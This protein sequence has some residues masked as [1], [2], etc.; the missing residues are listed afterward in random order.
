MGKVSS[1]LSVLLLLLKVIIPFCDLKLKSHPRSQFVLYQV[2][3][4]ELEFGFGFIF[5][6]QVMNPAGKEKLGPH[7]RKVSEKEYAN[8]LR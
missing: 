6:L 3:W 8:L 2:R 4:Q 1:L 5:Q 7:L